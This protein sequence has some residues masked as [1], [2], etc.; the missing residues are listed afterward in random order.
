VLPT[1][2]LGIFLIPQAMKTIPIHLLWYIIVQGKSDNP[3]GTYHH[4]AWFLNFKFGLYNMPFNYSLPQFQ[5]DG[6]HTIQND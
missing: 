1:R 3:I 6:L 4:M 2:N 5:F